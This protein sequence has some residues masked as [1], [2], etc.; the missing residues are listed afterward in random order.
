M[1]QP[2][3]ACEIYAQHDSMDMA[4]TFYCAFS[5]VCC[6]NLANNSQTYTRGI[7][8]YSTRQEIATAMN[9]LALH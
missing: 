9:A 7:V 3:R 6:S 2:S 4:R 8:Q 1:V 5:H